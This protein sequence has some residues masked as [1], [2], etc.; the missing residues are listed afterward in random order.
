MF[1]VF[2]AA[3]FPLTRQPVVWFVV[4]EAAVLASLFLAAHYYLVPLVGREK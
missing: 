3:L 1:I 2:F 4:G